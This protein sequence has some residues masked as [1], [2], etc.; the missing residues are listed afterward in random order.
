MEEDPDLRPGAAIKAAAR[1]L[2]IKDDPQ[3]IRRIKR[4]LRAASQSAEVQKTGGED[5]E[6]FLD[7]DDTKP[8]PVDPESLFDIV[9]QRSLQKHS[10]ARRASAIAEKQTS[11]R[12]YRNSV[13]AYLK[14]S[15]G[16]PKA[17]I[18]EGLEALRSVLRREAS[19]QLINL[20]PD[21][22]QWV[23]DE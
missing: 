23:I 9:F 22:N 3:Q 6:I 14:E 8:I 15:V 21:H 17:E 16:F 2:G 13:A 5:E 4:R 19:E 1:A 10:G 20:F 12:R 18:E 7:L 11:I